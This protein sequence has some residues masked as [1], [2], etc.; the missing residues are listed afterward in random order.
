MSGDAVAVVVAETRRAGAGRGRER[1]RVDYEE[2][3]S[4]HRRVEGD[5]RRA[6]RRFIRK[7][8]TT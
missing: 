6:S 4:V 3:P 7:R 2:L 1:S 8:K 5:G